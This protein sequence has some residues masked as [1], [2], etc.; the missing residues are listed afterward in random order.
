MR[1]LGRLWLAGPGRWG[2]AF[3]VSHNQ[4]QVLPAVLPPFNGLQLRRLGR[5]RRRCLLGQG[6]HQGG[7]WEGTPCLRSAGLES[8]KTESPCLIAALQVDRSGAYIA[9]QA[10]KS[11]V[12]SGLARRALVQVSYA[13]G[14][15]E[16]L[17]VFVD[18]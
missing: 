5:A 6:P 3:A 12:A 10:A 2:W 16:P 14:V 1:R 13:I 15:P 8:D 17:S 11:I 4:T 7:R 9:R 18:R